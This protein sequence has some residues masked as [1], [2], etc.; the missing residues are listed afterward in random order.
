MLTA[1]VEANYV[2]MPN[3]SMRMDVSPEVVAQNKA[4]IYRY[5]EAHPEQ[6]ANILLHGT[7]SLNVN[8]VPTFKIFSG[9]TSYPTGHTCFNRI[10]IKPYTTYEKFKSDMDLALTQS[11]S[12]TIG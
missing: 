10:D 7:A 3:G 8:N 12:F 11:N 1:R 2:T 6:W 9:F 4:F 5:I